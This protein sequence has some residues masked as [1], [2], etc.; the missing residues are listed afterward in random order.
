MDRFESSRGSR[1]YER[2]GGVFAQRPRMV[3]LQYRRSDGYSSIR[4][5]AL[6]RT[7]RE[8]GPNRSRSMLKVVRYFH[9]RAPQISPANVEGSR[10][11]VPV[12]R[13]TN[14]AFWGAAVYWALGGASS[15]VVGDA[16]RKLITE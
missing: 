15:L 3:S 6:G 7:S 8:R 10:G 16:K 11:A 12:L 14:I 4:S 5:V 2:I 1:A 9:Y 13:G